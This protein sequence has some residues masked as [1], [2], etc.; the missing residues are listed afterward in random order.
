MLQPIVPWHVFH[1]EVFEVQWEP[2]T[3][4]DNHIYRSVTLRMNVVIIQGKVGCLHSV[5]T[6]SNAL[7]DA[8]LDRAGP[9]LESCSCTQANVDIVPG[10]DYAE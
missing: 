4:S 2:I 8:L 6:Y 1:I 3:V 7:F 10:S 9:G 5:I